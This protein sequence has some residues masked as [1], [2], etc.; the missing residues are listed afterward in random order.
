A[1]DSRELDI[2]L[3]DLGAHG[4]NPERTDIQLRIADQKPL[5]YVGKPHHVVAEAVGGGRRIAGA[6]NQG[7][8]FVSNSLAE[9][10]LAAGEVDLLLGCRAGLGEVTRNAVPL[11]E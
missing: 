8:D 5:A 1:L 10:A 2:G 6:A 4:I 3:G 9:E 7:V 11:Q